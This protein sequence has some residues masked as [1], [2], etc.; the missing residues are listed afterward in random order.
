MLTSP[1]RRLDW[2]EKYPKTLIRVPEDVIKSQMGEN[3]MALSTPQL[4]KAWKDFECAKEKMAKFDFLGDTILIAPPTVDAF[5][6][7]AA[8]LR[9][10]GYQVR[11]KDTDSYNC[12]AITGGTE[13]SLHSYGIALDINWQTNPFIDHAGSRGPRFSIRTTQD[14]RALD[15]KAAKADTDM[16]KAMIADVI[17]I[18]TINGKQVFEWGGNWGTVKDAMHFEIDIAPQDLASGVDWSTV[19]GER[20]PASIHE[21]L[22]MAAAPPPDDLI[23]P[24]AAYSDAFL[25]CHV[26]IEKWEGGFVNDPQDPGGATNMGITQTVLSEWRG[27]PV[28][29]QDVKNLSREEARSI[30][31]ARYWKPLRCDQLPLP[32]A[33]MTY[34]CGVNSGIGRGGKFLQRSLN[35]Q[36]AGLTED[37]KV[38]QLSIQAAAGS[39]IAQAVKDYG[40]IYEAF[41]RSL[42]TFGRF[43]RGWMNR[44]TEIL[45][46]A[47]SWLPFAASGP[48]TADLL[49]EISAGLEDNNITGVSPMQ[50]HA[51]TQEMTAIDKVLGGRMMVGKKTLSAAGAYAA[52]MLAHKYGVLNVSAENYDTLVQLI[53]LYGGLSV[54]S[55]FERSGK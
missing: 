45:K 33:L 9:T 18:R 34:N 48:Q 25:K 38:G 4:R 24:T 41:Y 11:T 19:N 1:K 44:L 53:G 2:P 49:P 22:E 30:F 52:A 3:N 35:R 51:A 31:Y 8:V 14:Q 6:A 39:N 17:A 13:K 5:A 15:V 47:Y 40:D 55:K 21:E 37:G 42:A 54:A 16:T 26:L 43:G 28:S 12:R 20:T 46:L 23:A 50:I 36:G 27:H 7:L 29:V 10:H 32:L